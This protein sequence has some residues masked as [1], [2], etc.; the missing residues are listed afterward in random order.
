MAK[1]VFVFRYGAVAVDP[2]LSPTDM[3]RHLKK[4]YAWRDELAKAGHEPSGQPL[5]N[6]GKIVRGRDRIVTDGPF[7]ESKD[8]VTGTM[9][10]TCSSLEEAVALAHGCPIYEF[11]GS[12]EVR[13]VFSGEPPP[14][15]PPR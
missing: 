15:S 1:Y 13:P 8:L 9:L 2:P 11:D 10:L 3:E 7:T 14:P 5:E 4:W 6:G 12:V